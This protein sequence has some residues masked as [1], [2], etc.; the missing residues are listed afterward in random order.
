MLSWRVKIHD[1]S[2]KVTQSVHALLAVLSILTA[3][4]LTLENNKSHV[5]DAGTKQKHV[6]VDAGT[7]SYC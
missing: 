4:L 2:P 3:M 1:T 5:D 7:K 6:V